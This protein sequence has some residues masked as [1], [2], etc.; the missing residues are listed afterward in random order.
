MVRKIVGIKHPALHRKSKP[1]AKVDK[2][3]EQLIADLW[4]T[5]AAQKDPEGIGLAAPQVGKN[6]RVFIVSYGKV[7]QAFI[8]PKILKT[9][10]SAKDKKLKTKHKRRILEGCLSLPHY[11]S[12]IVRADKLRVKYLNEAGQEEEKEFTGFIA[13]IIGHEIDHLEGKVF[14]DH[15]LEQELPLYKFDGNDWEEVE[16]A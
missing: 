6:L 12:P 4:E 7:Q 15:T 9:S 13:Q 11:Y 5:L 8:N 16:L 1:V 3:V 14:I 2:K 10:K